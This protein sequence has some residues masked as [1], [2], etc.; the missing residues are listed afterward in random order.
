VTEE[1]P[2]QSALDVPD[3]ALAVVERVVD[4]QIRP[5]L[6]IH[7]GDIDVVSVSEHGDVE[8]EFKGG[9]R[10]CPL[11]TVTYAIAVR[12]R[13]LRLP[14]VQSVSVRG[15]RL[16]D[17]ALDRVAR[18]CSGYPLMFRASPADPAPTTRVTVA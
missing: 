8:L 7:G 6:Q 9:C 11:K 1:A 14:G 2:V 4:A 17:A 15:V 3:Q 16:S 13:L 18:S 5:L 10:A 12:E